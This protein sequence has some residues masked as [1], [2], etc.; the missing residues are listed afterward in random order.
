[1][2]SKSKKLKCYKR[3]GLKIYE[4]IKEMAEWVKKYP[5][6][7]LVNINNIEDV[8]REYSDSDDDYKKLLEEYKI[9]QSYYEYARIRKSKG[10]LTDKQSN[11][12]KDA[13]VGGVFGY[14]DE[15]EDLSKKYR[16]DKQDVLYLLNKYQSIKNFYKLYFRNEIEDAFDFNL[17]KS[18]IIRNAID[19]DGDLY[20][21]G[22][23]GLVNDLMESSSEIFI[24]S[25]KM[26]DEALTSLKP[27]ITSNIVRK[28]Y[29]LKGVRETSTLTSIGEEIGVSRERVRQR[30]K[31]AL[32]KLRGSNLEKMVFKFSSLEELLTED[33][34]KDF[35][36]I[37]DIVIDLCT[38][39]RNFDDEEV[40]KIF[41]LFKNIMQEKNKN[42]GKLDSINIEELEL[43]SKAYNCLK[44]SGYNTLEELMSL[45]MEDLLKI[46]RLGKKIAKEIMAKIEPYRESVEKDEKEEQ[47]NVSIER[48]GENVQDLSETEKSSETADYEIFETESV[49]EILISEKEKKPTALQLLKSKRDELQE[50]INQLKSKMSQAQLLLDECNIALGENKKRKKP[51]LDD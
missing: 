13:N 33:E 29:N 46:K 41:D 25:S 20:S 16:F 34:K 50:M 38:G 35:S 7:R 27:E 18:K 47:D 31:L 37:E 24:Y 42:K 19:I 32:E 4:K 10:K 36:Y 39:T 26:I 15:I 11:E 14:S 9:I 40:K 48:Q 51:N 5:N 30:K 21:A 28:K 1:M 3:K 17:A 2:V 8:L 44:K 23:N 12:I 43:S 6:A 22:Y 45:S 49:E